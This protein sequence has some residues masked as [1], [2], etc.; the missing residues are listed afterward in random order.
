MT[1]LHC[2]IAHGARCKCNRELPSRVSLVGVCMSNPQPVV[3]LRCVC[4]EVRQCP[5]VEGVS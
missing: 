1:T 2:K 4:G 5:L 3:I